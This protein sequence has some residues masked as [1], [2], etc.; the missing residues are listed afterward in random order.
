MLFTLHHFYCCIMGKG[1]FDV[2]QDGDDSSSDSSA[3]GQSLKS[4]QNTSVVVPSFEDLSL[5]RGDEETVLEA[6]YGPDFTR[7]LDAEGRAT[8]LNVHV[9]P[10][11][12]QK[13]HVGTQLTLS[14]KLQKQYP[15]VL[16]TIQLKKVTGL[17]AGEQTQLMKQLTDRAKQLS[18]SGSVMMVDLVQLT[19]D[20][21]LEHN[22]DPTMSAWEEMKAREKKEEEQERQL[23]QQ[24]QAEINSLLMDNNL[25][26]RSPMSSS[27]RR[28][29]EQRWDP[30]SPSSNNNLVMMDDDTPRGEEV[31]SVDI[32]R[33]LNRQMEAFE[34]ARRIQQKGD[35]T[36]TNDD[37]GEHVGVNNQQ[38][39]GDFNDD[40]YD[41]DQSDNDDEYLYPP[42]TEN[43]GGMNSRYQ[44]D[45]IELGV[46]G[47]GGGG[48]V[49]KVRNRLDRRIYAVK[50]IILESE[51]GAFA[52]AGAVQNR[53]LRR[54]VTTISRMTH[55]N[56][57]RYYQA[58]VEGD[59][60]G[61]IEEAV[62]L[63][64][65]FSAD[66]AEG[67]T[68]MEANQDDNDELSGSGDSNDGGGY[69]AKP[70]L[71]KFFSH[72]GDDDDD[73]DDDDEDDSS[74]SDS[75]EDDATSE[76]DEFMDMTSMSKSKS[77]SQ[78]RN[79]QSIENLLE[80]ENSMQVCTT[81]SVALVVLVTS[82]YS[83]K[84]YSACK[85]FHLVNHSKVR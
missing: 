10:P 61:N 48:E 70:S 20:F 29:V 13:D 58:W 31:A 23:E 65:A 4:A 9:R 16:P 85:F 81:F 7:K 14:L 36:D 2:L 28:T 1:F 44:A 67:K 57:V 84:L 11:D 76:D 78:G 22:R 35:G 18:Q 15:Y 82:E 66:L 43:W 49:V 71:G 37:N 52:V 53:K 40:D 6:V 5:C 51:R 41:D 63:E 25:R 42:P 73:D 68:E 77:S 17:S 50:K 26:S 12:T 24:Q 45:F 69:W 3:S 30:R 27:Q 72:D 83:N 38:L 56:I 75:S 59:D 55:K 39:V 34:V 60:K 74:E 19:E 80:L 62:K 21:L 79:S 46:L 32:K 64:R 33:E 8:R 54:E 47:R